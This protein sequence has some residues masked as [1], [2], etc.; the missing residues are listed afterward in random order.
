LE[1]LDDWV[2]ET[3]LEILSKEFIAGFLNMMQKLGFESEVGAV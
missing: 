3:V 2:P 1:T